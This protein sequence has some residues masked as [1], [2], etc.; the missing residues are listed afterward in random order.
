MNAPADT[1]PTSRQSA[2]N[3][4]I[5]HFAGLF[6][7]TR[8]AAG[9]SPGELAELR[10]MDPNGVLPSPCWRLLGHVE[11]M[12][13]EPQERAWALLIRTMLEAGGSAQPGLPIGAALSAAEGG[14]DAYAEQRF[15]RLLRA[16]RL[17]DIAHEAR[18]AARWCVS[19]GRRIDFRDQARRPNGFGGFILA[20]ALNDKDAAARRAHA[21]ARDYFASPRSAT[22]PEP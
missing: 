19:R 2:A 7:R 17:D 8:E 6:E 22:A 9:L 14:N 13:G 11:D 10:R 16:R 4:A 3:Q 18:Q 1:P 20:A 15:I 21:I 5:G 12:H